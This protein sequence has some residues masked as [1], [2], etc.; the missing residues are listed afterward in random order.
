MVRIPAALALAMKELA[1]EDVTT[2]TD[3][4]KVAVREHL[5]RRGRWP[6]KSKR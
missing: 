6:V 4:V 3:Q 5:I 1:A 2:L